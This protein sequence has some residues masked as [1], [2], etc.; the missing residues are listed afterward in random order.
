MNVND[1]LQKSEYYLH[2]TAHPAVSSLLDISRTCSRPNATKKFT[3]LSSAKWS[4]GASL[5]LRAEPKTVRSLSG[6]GDHAQTIKTARLCLR[7]RWKQ[8]E[9]ATAISTRTPVNRQT[10]ILARQARRG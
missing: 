6:E 8:I 9:Q 2:S 1:S 5:K 10:E 7:L 3:G 4:D